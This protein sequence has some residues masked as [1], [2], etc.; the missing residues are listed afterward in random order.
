MKPTFDVTGSQVTAM[1]EYDIA[2]ATNLAL[3]TTVKLTAGK[4]VQA[5]VGE[6]AAILGSTAEIHTGAADTFNPRNNGL[7]IK[8]FDS[9]TQ[10]FETEAPQLTATGGTNATLIVNDATLA[11]GFADDDFNGGFMKLISKAAASTNTDPLG[12]V[13]PI[14]D[15]VTA[16]KTFTTTQVAGGAITVGDVFAIFPPVGFAKG[17]L[18]AAFRKY[19]LSATAALAIRTYGR[20]E[21]RNKVF[22]E[23]VLHQ[24]GN[25]QA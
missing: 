18:D 25:K 14:T 7:K 12:T 5:A 16:T 17:N 24:N 22:A 2:A 23:A 4:V 15:F 10:I 1:K 3:N 13:Y 20:D 6:T 9:P 19:D 11:A 8:V 21:N